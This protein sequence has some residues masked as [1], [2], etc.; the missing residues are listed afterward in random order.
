MEQRKDCSFCKRLEIA[1]FIADSEKRERRRTG[2][3]KI[4]REYTVAFVERTWTKAKGKRRAG[5]ITDYRYRGI[6]YRLNYCPEC[7]R[8]IK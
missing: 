6:G 7:G 1:A 3:V 5:R 8:K 2:Q 4:Y